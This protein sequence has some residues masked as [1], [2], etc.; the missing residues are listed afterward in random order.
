VS[1][2]RAAGVALLALAALP[3]SAVAATDRA[4]YAAQANSV[5]ASAKGNDFAELT[6]LRSLTPAPG[7][8]VLV[9]SWLDARQRRLELGRELKQIDRQVNKLVKRTARTRNIDTL[10]RIDRKVR[11]LDRRADHV[12][13]KL[14][15]AEI[16][17]DDLG[18]ELGATGCIIDVS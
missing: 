2:R 15:S 10:I 1:K 13:D 18:T 5:C 16:Q 4:D 11:K 14:I 6:G 17:D 8:E 12:Q 7:D 3:A 9:A